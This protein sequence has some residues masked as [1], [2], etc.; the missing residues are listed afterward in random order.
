MSLLRQVLRF[1]CECSDLGLKSVAVNCFKVID[2][3]GLLEDLVGVGLE[4][5]LQ[6]LHLLKDFEDVIFVFG[7]GIQGLHVAHLLQCLRCGR[8][9]A[10]HEVTHGLVELVLSDKVQ[11]N[12]IQ[13]LR[14]SCLLHVQKVANDARIFLLADII[15]CSVH[16]D[17][18]HALHLLVAQHVVDF[19]RDLGL[20]RTLLQHMLL[21][22]L[23]LELGHFWE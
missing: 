10:E 15:T 21:N 12:F 19:G 8:T 13:F 14:T 18:L 16:A 5:N 23:L 20:V 22:E 3:F 4:V 11:A 2:A 7:H 9:V 1:L 17:D 6:K